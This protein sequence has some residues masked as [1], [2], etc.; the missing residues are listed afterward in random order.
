MRTILQVAT[1]IAVS[2]LVSHIWHVDPFLVPV[3]F[4][5]TR[6]NHRSL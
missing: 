1:L 5:V 3:I 4:G 2:I 6:I